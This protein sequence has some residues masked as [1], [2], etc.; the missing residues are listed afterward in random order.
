MDQVQKQMFAQPLMITCEQQ[1]CNNN[2]DTDIE[3]RNKNRKKSFLS[4]VISTVPNSLPAWDITTSYR[5][6]HQEKPVMEKYTIITTI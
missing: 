4:D 2:A 6:L 1:P 3:N 5:D